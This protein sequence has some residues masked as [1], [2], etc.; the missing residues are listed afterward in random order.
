MSDP[1]RAQLQEAYQLIKSGKKQ[2]AV[3]LLQ[4]VLLMDR[5][6]PDAWWLLANASDDPAEQ[7]EALE[8]VLRLRP[9]HEQAQQKLNSLKAAESFSFDEPAPTDWRGGLMDTEKPKNTFQASSP[10]IVEKPRSGTNPLL[11]ILAII[12]LV[13]LLLFGACFFLVSQFTAQFG[14]VVATIAD[15]ITAMPGAFETIAAMGGEQQ[16]ANIDDLENKGSISRGENKSDTLADSFSYHGY[17][18]QG[19]TG[20]SMTIEVRAE[21]SDLDT[22]V[23]IYNP[24]GDLLDSNDDIDFGTDTNSRLTVTLPTSG[25]YTIVVS[26]FASEGTYTLS[27]D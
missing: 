2:D 14:N 15:S 5:N 24:N 7:R 13:A 20:Q 8:T 21:S 25:I 9:T 27:V 19:E 16:L 12:G 4:T 18:L 11:V 22:K 1:T 23:A 3:Q 26:S 10:I 6:N 17:T